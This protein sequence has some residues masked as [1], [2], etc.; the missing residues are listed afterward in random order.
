MLVFL[1]ASFFVLKCFRYELFQHSED[2]ARYSPVLIRKGSVGTLT[3][4]SP[5]ALRGKLQ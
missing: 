1:A 2:R 4:S 5:W 3:L